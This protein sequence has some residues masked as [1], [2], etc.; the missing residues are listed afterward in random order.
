MGLDDYVAHLRSRGPA[1]KAV[2]MA[3]AAF[4]RR[5][6]PLHE[7]IPMR[8]EAPRRPRPLPLVDRGEMSMSWLRRSLWLGLVV[9]GLG[10]A[11]PSAWSQDYGA[12]EAVGEESS[13]N[14]LYGY[15]GVAA[16]GGVAI[17]DAVQDL[18]SIDLAMVRRSA[19]GRLRDRQTRSVPGIGDIEP[20]C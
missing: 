20:E 17:V 3:R 11:A 4:R 5:V 8:E 14:P 10:V 13:G 12:E 7:W 19:A 15:L 6:R 16:I 2:A 1:W 18:A 9:I